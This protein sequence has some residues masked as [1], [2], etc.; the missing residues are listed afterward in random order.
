MQPLGCK[1][2]HG[3]S[4]GMVTARVAILGVGWWGTVAH[5]APLANDPLAEVVAVWSRT[6]EKAKQRA[7]AY[8]V[9]HAYTDWRAL[10]DECA[11]D[12]VIVASTP[13][14]HYAQARYALEHGLHV[15]VEKPFVIE[16]GQATALQRLAADRG[17]LLGVCHPML[18][19]EPLQSA[20][21]VLQSGQLGRILLVSGHFSQRCYELYHGHAGMSRRAVDLDR[22]APNPNSYSDPAIAGGGEGHTQ[23]SHIVGATLW[24]TGLRPASVFAFMQNL[25]APVDVVNALTIQYEG[26]ALGTIT[27]NGL[28]ARETFETEIQIQGELGTMYLSSRSNPGAGTDERCR[29][30]VTYPL[31]TRAD[32]APAAEKVPRNFVRA[33]LGQEELRVGTQVA[34]DEARILTAA[35]CSVA[36]GCPAQVEPE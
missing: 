36:T 24:L 35:Y 14:M 26:G 19:Y 10:I 33:I 17:L 6:E 2:S 4:E 34:V 20:R 28:V 9:P 11:L 29:G 15:L 30:Y 8:G 3:G 16:T 5:L 25:D 22:P 27:A 32:Y 7:Q 12:G 13:N 21:Q 23:A 18:F 1:L 31:P